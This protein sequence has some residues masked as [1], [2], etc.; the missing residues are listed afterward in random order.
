MGNSQSSSFSTANIKDVLFP[1][2]KPDPNAL[3]E[4]RMD[5]K[6]LSDYCSLNKKMSRIDPSYRG[7]MTVAQFSQHFDSTNGNHNAKLLLRKF[8]HR[9][10][11]TTFNSS[12]NLPRELLFPELYIVGRD[13]SAYH[14]QNPNRDGCMIKPTDIDN[15]GDSVRI[16]L[17][18][19]DDH[20]QNPQIPQDMTP[21]TRFISKELSE[22]SEEEDDEPGVFYSPPLSRS[23][24]NSTDELHKHETKSAASQE[25]EQEQEQKQKE[26]YDDTD[27]HREIIDIRKR[28]TNNIV[29][30]ES[31]QQ[32][33][34]PS[35]T[36]L[37][38]QSRQ[39][40]RIKFHNRSKSEVSKSTLI[41]RFGFGKK[42][43]TNHC[44]L[45]VDTESP[46]IDFP[47]ISGNVLDNVPYLKDG[48]QIVN[49]SQQS[50]SPSPIS[51]TKEFEFLLSDNP[52]PPKPS[53]IHSNTNLEV[54]RSHQPERTSSIRGY[55]GRLKPTITTNE[56][57]NA[58]IPPKV[59]PHRNLTSSELKNTRLSPVKIKSVTIGEDGRL[60]SI[61]NT[62]KNNNSKNKNNGS[63]IY[64]RKCSFKKRSTSLSERKTD[65][66]KIEQNVDR[67]RFM[68]PGYEEHTKLK[69]VN[70]DEND[71]LSQSSKRNST[72]EL[73]QIPQSRTYRPRQ[74]LVQSCYTKTED[75]YYG[76]RT[77]T[78]VATESK[79]EGDIWSSRGKSFLAKLS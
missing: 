4:A 9:E 55:N 53:R 40:S 48:D 74:R 64:T 17:D 44:G 15:S 76:S 73:N 60:P 66:E 13:G 35:M 65:D 28:G 25:Q 38:Q 71:E 5:Y 77:G 6:T 59:P 22:S 39:E 62:T 69:V 3:I 20:V 21:T 61:N 75:Y 70:S 10:I 72:T 30:S 19:D 33:R 54:Y 56:E 2:T 42:K 23:S 41:Q 51:P 24:W 11:F 32:I 78:F 8:I 47:D 14:C 37:K 29:T 7:D 1:A 36:M 43:K 79:D 31:K 26:M 57:V 68:L 12:R 46:T 67:L 52:R 27:G 58:G 63:Q 50:L 16:V 18:I 34:S 45:N 49:Y